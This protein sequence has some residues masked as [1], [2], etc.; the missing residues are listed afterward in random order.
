MENV[1]EF[2]KSNQPANRAFETVEDVKLAVRR[3]WLDFIEDPNRIQSI[4]YREWADL[5]P[6]ANSASVI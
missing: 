3:A 4:T 6:G 1:F 5:S 2:L